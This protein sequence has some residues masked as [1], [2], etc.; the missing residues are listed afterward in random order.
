LTTD[1]ILSRHAP[2]DEAEA[3]DLARIRAFVQR[4]PQPFDRA[5]AEG[6]RPAARWC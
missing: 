2:G 6:H 4:H 5:I 3:A 1:E